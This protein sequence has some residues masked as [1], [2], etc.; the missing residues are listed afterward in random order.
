[1]TAGMHR[2]PN[3]RRDALHTA[4]RDT[5][6]LIQL[7]WLVLTIPISRRARP[8]AAAGGATATTPPAEA[9]GAPAAS[10][11]PVRPAG[12][13]LQLPGAAPGGATA[14]PGAAARP[15]WVWYAS[16]H[17][18]WPARTDQPRG[19]HPYPAPAY[20]IQAIPLPGRLAVIDGTGAFAAIRQ[21]VPPSLRD[22]GQLEAL[23]APIVRE[24]ATDTATL[25]RLLGDLRA[26]E[27]S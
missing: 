6:T 25:T 18:P 1:M 5:W 8:V 17:G 4:A 19:Q 22:T 20:N 15:D 12:A 14:P 24:W 11:A 23:A 10:V 27:V 9:P 7:S 16:E 26:L 13:P 3:Q 2:R 21:P